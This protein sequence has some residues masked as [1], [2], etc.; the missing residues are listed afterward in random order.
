MRYL[1][2]LVPRPTVSAPGISTVAAVPE[3]WKASQDSHGECEM[4]RL[5]FGAEHSRGR[6]RQVCEERVAIAL[7][8]DG[9]GWIGDD[10]IGTAHRP[11]CLGSRACRR[12]RCQF[13][14]IDVVQEHV[15]GTDSGREVDFLT[16]RSPAA[17]FPAEHLC[18]LEEQRSRSPGRVVHLVH[19]SCPRP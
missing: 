2:I 1:R 15:Y 9:V 19:P 13:V 18:E 8:V 16:E 12:G 14:E 4:T 17:R 3:S 10:R 11:E 7:P 5:G 6:K